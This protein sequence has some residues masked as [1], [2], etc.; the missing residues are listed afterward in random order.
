MGF[1]TNIEEVI[2]LSQAKEDKMKLSD[3]KAVFEKQRICITRQG[4]KECD[5]KCQECD[6]VLP[7]KTVYDAYST[8][9][10]LIDYITTYSKGEH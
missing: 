9:I 1:R 3:V 10:A 7:R 6:L 4:T 8:A 5:R 2:T